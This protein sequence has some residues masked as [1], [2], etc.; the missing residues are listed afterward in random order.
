MPLLALTRANLLL[1]VRNRQLLVFNVLVPLLL[2][3]IFGGLFQRSQLNVDVAAPAAYTQVFEKALSSKSFSL[4]RVSPAQ[5]RRD[6]LNNSVDFAL[7]VK[8][9]PAPGEPVVVHVQENSGNVTQNGSLTAAAQAAVAALNQAILKRPP[10]AVT[11]VESVHPP[12]GTSAGSVA[13]TN[14]IAFLT[15][16]IL[17]YSV[18]TAG[19]T[20]GVRLVSY[21]EQGTLRRIRATPLP[22]WA[23]LMANV[24]SQVVLVAIQVAVLL[25]VGHLMYGVGMGPSPGPVVLILLVG[26]LCFLAGGF[27]IS[28]LARSEQS[29]IVITNLVLL[30]QLFVAGI[31][32][33]LSGAPDWL[34]KLSTVMPLTY[35]ADG[36]R[37][38][39]AEG[40]PLS[41]TTLDLLVLLGV[42]LAVLL[43]AVRTFRFSPAATA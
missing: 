22:V 14:Y 35:F 33:P 12:G 38:L 19:L 29:A 3:V 34:Q 6:V 25:G 36:L 31:F 43:I 26:C 10:A 2:I 11:Q 21:R 39:M 42:G 8:S 28:G 37:S 4:H 41:Y 18:L 32:Y 15:P 5:A 13:N 16:G 17:A 7:V 1:I 40:R 20:A 27:F 30:P 24:A 9:V 23:F